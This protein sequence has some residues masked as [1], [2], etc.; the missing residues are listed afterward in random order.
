[1]SVQRVAGMAQAV[2]S[3]VHSN[4]HGHHAPVIAQST[5]Q[6]KDNGPCSSTGGKKISTEDIQLVQN[7][8]ERCLQLYMPQKEVVQTLQNQAKIEP[9]F[10]T[11]VWQKLEEQNPEFFRAYHIRLKVKDQVVMFNHLLDQQFQLMQK[12]YRSWMQTLPQLMASRPGMPMPPMPPMPPGMPLH[13]Q[14]PIVP[15]SIEAMPPYMGMM[16]MKQPQ[17]APLGGTDQQPQL[18]Q[19]QNTAQHQQHAPQQQQQQQQQQQHN[20]QQQNLQQQQ[21]E[22]HNQQHQQQPVFPISFSLQAPVSSLPY[23]ISRPMSSMDM[24]SCSLPHSTSGMDHMALDLLG[25]PPLSGSHTDLMAAFGI[26]SSIL[27]LSSH[28]LGLSSGLGLE[29]VDHLV[30]LPK[31]FSFSDL[32]ALD[33]PTQLG[34]DETDGV[35]L[36]LANLGD[37]DGSGMGSLPR[38]F[39]FSDMNPL[40]LDDLGHSK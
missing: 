33:L 39:S 28:S 4:G 10:T 38:N 36:H 1:M 5:Q 35:G 29:P 11:L 6:G 13:S 20:H 34:G 37:G 32:N 22:Q 2:Q 26:S 16:G 15:M 8:I 40:D 9:G 12:L 23:S 27:M 18:Q 24:M 3:S 31:V 17:P 7:L 25:P 14:T 21:A 30:G 19:H